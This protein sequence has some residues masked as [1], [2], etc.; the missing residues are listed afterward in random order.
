MHNEKIPR[1]RYA[2]KLLEKGGV[3]DGAEGKAMGR[4]TG[5]QFVSKIL[6]RLY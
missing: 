1:S 6:V 5:S 4:V 2:H 3:K